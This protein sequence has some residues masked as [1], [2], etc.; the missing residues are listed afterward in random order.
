MTLTIQQLPTAD[1]GSDFT[2]CEDDTHQLSG[3]ADR[4][5]S[6]LWTTSG[7]GTFSNENILNPIYTPGAA[8]IVNGAV[9]LTLTA[10]PVSPCVIFATDEILLTIDSPQITSDLMNIEVNNGETLEL[11]FEVQTQIEGAFTWYFNGELI[12]NGNSSVFVIDEIAPADAGYYNAIFSNPCGTLESSVALVEVVQALTHQKNLPQG[13]S[14][15]SSFVVPSQ[16]AMPDIFADIVDDLVLISDNSAVYWPGENINTLENWSL[17]TGYRIKMF[18]SNVLEIAGVIRYPM[19]ELTIPSGWSYLPVNTACMV[20]VEE[21]FTGLPQIAFIKDI[22]GINLYWP[23]YGVNTLENLIPGK[24]YEI[25]NTS[26]EP[27][28]IIYPFCDELP[29]LWDFKDGSAEIMHPWNVIHK[30]PVSHV[31]GFSS[32]ALV[33]F[34]EGDIIGAFTADGLCAGVMQIGNNDEMNVLT[35]F[36]TDPLLIE[37]TGF[38][39]GEDVNFRLIRNNENEPIDL[40]TACF[41]PESQ[42]K[43]TFTANGISIIDF[44]EFSTNAFES[45]KIAAPHFKIDIFPNPTTGVINI[46]FQTNNEFEGKMIILN[47]TGQTILHFDL[48]QP[49]GS[50]LQSFDLSGNPKGVYYLKIVSDN[51]STAGKI[52]VR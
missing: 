21:M 4:Y 30:T 42:Q 39:T 17:T 8:D 46:G 52:I 13:W 37:K 6:L 36:A 15:I 1:A 26:D 38:S 20:N 32:A 23:Q 7:A 5:S 44:I 12:E 35:S 33:S 25:L 14:G 49:A 29:Q 10:E 11:A 24:A 22:A 41:A 31:F 34:K 50:S 27:V 3:Q 51:F 16:A 45:N 2:I 9:V 28:T 40:V 48:L 43:N 18:S 19:V 47:S